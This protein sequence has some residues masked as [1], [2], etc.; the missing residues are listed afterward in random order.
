[1]DVMSQRTSGQNA[2]VIGA[3][4]I[5][6]VKM[7]IKR[8]GTRMFDQAHDE[9]VG[10][11]GALFI[12]CFHP[13]STTNPVTTSPVKVT[14]FAR[15][16]EP[17]VAGYGVTP[18]SPAEIRAKV[19]RIP[20]KGFYEKHSKKVT[21]HSEAV[22]KSKSGV[23]SGVA[24]ALGGIAPILAVSPLAEFAP[25][26]TLAG[27]AAPFLKSFGLDKPNDLRAAQPTRTDFFGDQMGGHGLAA[28]T[29]L[30]LHPEASLGEVR[31]MS[32]LKR[33]SLT[34][35]MSRPQ[36]VKMGRIDSVIPVNDP[37]EHFPV[38]PTMCM[39]VGNVYYPSHMA[40]L[41][42]AFHRWRGTIKIHI[43]FVTA[44]FTTTRVRISHLPNAEL[45]PSLEDYAGDAT[46]C[47]VDVRGSTEFSFACPHYSAYAYLPISGYYMP[48]DAG[49][50]LAVPFVC[51]HVAISL[52]NPVCI[53][54]S[55]GDSS[56]YYSIWVAC[57]EDFTLGTFDTWYP[58]P[59]SYVA[60]VSLESSNQPVKDIEDLAEEFEVP[61]IRPV[62][63][64]FRPKKTTLRSAYEKHSVMDS[65]SKPFKALV[66]ANAAAEAGFITPEQ[67][68]SIEDLCHRYELCNLNTDESA[69]N[70][71][72]RGV[73]GTYGVRTTILEVLA[74]TFQYYRGAFRYKIL[75]HQ[76]DPAFMQAY[77][78]YDN[79]N[80]AFGGPRLHK[81]ASNQPTLD[82]E[83][84]WDEYS[85]CRPIVEDF[86]EDYPVLP[87]SVLDNS[88]YLYRG[89]AAVQCTTMRAA[90]EDFVFG[91]QVPCQY[92]SPIGAESPKSHV[93]SMAATGKA[94]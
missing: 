83:I 8:S 70:V 31:N 47:V 48:G 1:M 28:A 3:S 76:E 27:A 62:R 40:L 49:T 94:D 81:F 91:S 89:G 52:L 6:S 93:S 25:I 33:H 74:T 22:E 26:A 71:L 18:L 59:T 2:T 79:A 41:S 54:D 16:V 61:D 78:Y 68:T 38:A 51:P 53:P 30:A 36:C 56:I 43:K 10:E 64:K 92:Y 82:I 66:P 73:T 4:S 19:R 11:I 87:A 13:L 42:Q 80:P 23:I 35:Y 67:Y 60:P 88:I 9:G 72:W 77:F 21:P 5:N 39:R 24:E 65:F 17:H 50:A 12:D 90:G 20:H 29:K 14:V 69:P 75:P 7:I 84:P 46:S 63:E 45:P 32:Q 44:K 15:F 34:E 85:Y 57:G 58:R 86:D 55:T 37:F